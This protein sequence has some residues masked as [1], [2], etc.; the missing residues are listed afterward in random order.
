MNNLGKWQI[1]SIGSRFAALLLGILQSIIIT[2]V[3]SVAEFGIIGI[4]GA[5]G[6]LFGI[7]QHFGLASGTT[8]EVSSAKK[9]EVFQIF[10]ASLI[11]KYA[12][13][14]PVAFALFVLTPYITESFYKLS[15]IEFPLRLYTAVLLI[16]GAQGILNSVIAGM[17]RFR[18]L[19]IYQVA[20]AALSLVLYIPLVYQFRVNGYYIALLLF[21]LI[22]TIS[23]SFLALWPL[24]GYLKLPTRRDLTHS[25]KNILLLSLGIYLAKVLYTAWFK[26]GQFTLGKV[27]SLEVVGIFSFAVLFSSKLQTI[28]DALTDVN[29]P[30][31]S[32][33][34]VEDIDNFKK[35]FIQNFKRIFVLILFAALSASFFAKD[36]ILFAVGNKYDASIRLIFPLVFSFSFYSY[37]N[38]LKS[39]VLIPAKMIYEMIA[40]YILMF[41]STVAAYFLLISRFESLSSMSYAML[42]GSALSFAAAFY[43]IH[44]KLK[45]DVLN[46]RALILTLQLLVLAPFNFLA[47]PF[48]FKLAIYAGYLGLLYW[49]FKK[50]GF[51]AKL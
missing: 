39:S 50:E 7:A 3:L 49:S 8:R 19:F 26:F 41:V 47:L 24:R 11:I 28:S 40:A 31:F 14:I 36:A 38:L 13:V 48:V 23:L 51:F 37:L 29:L 20:I 22:S 21:N 42:I 15:E 43:M 25:V 35:S 30:V 32:K 6:A 17:Q 27:E 33:G 2:R 5:I 12:I 9:E 16:Q 46:S 18:R 45:F 44:N 4:V 10:L 34:F 1:I